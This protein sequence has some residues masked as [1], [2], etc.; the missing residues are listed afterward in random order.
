MVNGSDRRPCRNVSERTITN[1]VPRNFQIPVLSVDRANRARIA[2][3]CRCIR[4]EMGNAGNTVDPSRCPENALRVSFDIIREKASPS[5]FLRREIGAIEPK[6][7]S[8]DFCALARSR[9]FEMRDR[10]GIARCI[11]RYIARARSCLRIE[12]AN[13][14]RTDIDLSETNKRTLPGP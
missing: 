4:L 14:S 13:Y 5:P 1:G 12:C 9:P 7:Q 8:G 11:A 2:R 3:A 6:V 10:R